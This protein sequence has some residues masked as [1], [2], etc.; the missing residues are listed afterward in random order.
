ME[1]IIDLKGTLI[2]M[3]PVDPRLVMLCQLSSLSL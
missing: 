1:L 3:S 2:M